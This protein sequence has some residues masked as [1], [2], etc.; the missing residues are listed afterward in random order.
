[1][2][3]T[4]ASF[5][6]F[7]PTPI[8]GCCSTPTKRSPRLSLVLPRPHRDP[9]RLWPSKPPNRLPKTISAQQNFDG[10][11]V[12]DTK[13]TAP[14]DAQKVRPAR[15]QGAKRR[16]RTL[17]YVELLSEARTPLA[18]FFSILLTLILLNGNLRMVLPKQAR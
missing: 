10:L 3:Y 13:R 4:R 15:P 17:R 9:H 14:Q 7:L 16:R 1:M 12:W 6:R 5:N 18:D 11:H 8:A 2:R